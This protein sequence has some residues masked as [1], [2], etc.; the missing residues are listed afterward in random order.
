[1]DSKKKERNFM[2]RKSFL[3]IM[4]CSINLM[5][6]AQN[7]VDLGLPSG[8]L[9][10][11][12][13]VGAS[14][15]SDY[16]D[17]YAWGET[18]T[19]NKFSRFEYRYYSGGRYQSIGN[20]ITNTGYDV[21]RQRWGGNWRMPTKEEFQELIDK[22]TWTWTS[23]D[24]HYGYIVSYNGN[25]I[26]LPA[27]GSNY[28]SS[29]SSINEGG[30]YWLSEIGEEDYF[31]LNCYITSYT[32]SIYD[33]RREYGLCVRPVKSGQKRSTNDLSA[34]SL[35]SEKM[36]IITMK[37]GTSYTGKLIKLVPEV[38]IILSIAGEQTT[39]E[40][41]K[42]KSIK[43]VTSSESSSGSK[44]SINGNSTKTIHVE[45]HRDPVPV[46]QWQACFA[47]G[48]MGTM[49]CDNCGGGGTKYI[50]DRL[51]RCSRCNGR[52]IIPCNVCY[53]NKGQYITVYQ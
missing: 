24:G 43:E 3:L 33:N 19:K 38:R 12:R 36:V 44:P 48:G 14:S 20:N 53:G 11:D 37:S 31:A 47:C 34:N 29:S 28:G 1:M 27:A 8:T 13:N 40:M 45:H 18:S 30:Y 35:S 23:Q 6:K 10:A 7:A 15:P 51:H 42:V 16:G 9:W 25:S 17:Y 21:A 5:V 49:G 2:L 41:D 39:I 52:G 46:Q 4:M 26:F 32:H 50:G 22:C